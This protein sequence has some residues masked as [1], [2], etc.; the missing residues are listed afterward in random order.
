MARKHLLLRLKCLCEI[1]KV[2][3]IRLDRQAAQGC[4]GEKRRQ[5]IN[6]GMFRLHQLDGRKDT[7]LKGQL[8]ANIVVLV[9]ILKLR[10]GEDHVRTIQTDGLNK[11]HTGLS[12]VE[13]HLVLIKGQQSSRLCIAIL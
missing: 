2:L 7:A 6:D 12:V 8:A 3:W 5:M 11:C 10:R 13:Q 4:T 9:I 1:H